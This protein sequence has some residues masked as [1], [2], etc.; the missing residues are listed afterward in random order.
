MQNLSRHL[1][2]SRGAAPARRII[3]GLVGRLLVDSS[4]VGRSSG[5]TGRRSIGRSGGGGGDDGSA[6]GGG[7]V[8]GGQ[9]TALAD[10][11]HA[12]QE[13]DEE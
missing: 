3:L 1:G 10:N 13:R 5:R 2:G 4:V 8:L 11:R 6:V 7:S 9:A 12:Q